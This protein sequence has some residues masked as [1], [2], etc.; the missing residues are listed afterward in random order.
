MYDKIVVK[1]IDWYSHKYNFNWDLKSQFKIEDWT[2]SVYSLMTNCLH[3]KITIPK[4]VSLNYHYHLSLTV[5]YFQSK[6]CFMAKW[7]CSKINWG[8]LTVVYGLIC[9]WL[10]MN[11]YMISIEERERCYSFVLTW[12]PHEITIIIACYFYYNLLSIIINRI[13]SLLCDAKAHFSNKRITL[14]NVSAST[15]FQLELAK[16]LVSVS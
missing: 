13:T 11:V 14:S 15:L 3:K 9:C 16:L 5:K 1:G 2:P 12:T 10:F 7:L 8:N 6:L 4:K